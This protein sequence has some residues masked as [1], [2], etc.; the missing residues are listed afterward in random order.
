MRVRGS[1][2]NLKYIASFWANV[3]HAMRYVLTSLCMLSRN[4]TSSEQVEKKKSGNQRQCG[5]EIPPRG[6]Q[7]SLAHAHPSLGTIV[8]KIRFIGW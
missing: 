5:T 6:W 3:P 8:R 1:P 7:S 4:N 2:R